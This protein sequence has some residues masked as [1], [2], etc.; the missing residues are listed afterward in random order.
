MSAAL[1]LWLVHGSFLVLGAVLL[2]NSNQP[3]RT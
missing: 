1:G 3:A 2:K